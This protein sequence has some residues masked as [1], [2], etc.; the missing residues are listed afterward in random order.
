LYDDSFMSNVWKYDTLNIIM[1]NIPCNN[2]SS[3][4]NCNTFKILNTHN[5]ILSI[6]WKC[7]R[8]PFSPLSRGTIS[9]QRHNAYCILVPKLQ[10][11]IVGSLRLKIRCFTLL[12]KQW[13][14]GPL[15]VKILNFRL[16][17]TRIL[18][19]TAYNY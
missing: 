2:I 8:T 6:Q 11:M 3:T 5:T 19:G 16:Y 18:K 1:C 9:L 7:S 12:S 17:I 4:I 10:C 14:G 15:T 13:T